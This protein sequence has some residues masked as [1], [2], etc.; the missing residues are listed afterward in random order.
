MLGDVGFNEGLLPGSQTTV[1][2]LYLHLIKKKISLGLFYKC[3][4]PIPEGSTL[5]TSSP[6][7]GL[8]SRPSPP[9]GLITFWLR[10]QCE[11]WG[12]HNHSVYSSYQYIMAHLRHQITMKS[13]LNS[14]S[15]KVYLFY[16]F[17]VLLPFALHLCTFWNLPYYVSSLMLRLGLINL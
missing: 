12:W 14:Q 8:T 9:K 13:S 17:A 2:L 10:F 6:P 5:K 7:K 16:L 15:S 1:L 3:T 11:F 4:N